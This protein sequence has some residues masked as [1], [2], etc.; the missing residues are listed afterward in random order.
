MLVSLSPRKFSY[1]QHDVFK[2]MRSLLYWKCGCAVNAS[3][4]AREV[5][6][7]GRDITPKMVAS[8]T[9]PSPGRR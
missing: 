3:N 8:R 1:C 2:I 4:C 5:K 7:V 6:G 9:N